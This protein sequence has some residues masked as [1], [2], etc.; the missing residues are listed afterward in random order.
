[1]SSKYTLLAAPPWTS[2]VSPSTDLNMIAVCSQRAG[3]GYTPSGSS[4]LD[5]SLLSM[6]YVH[7][8]SSGAKEAEEPPKTTILDPSLVVTALCIHRADGRVPVASTLVHALPSYS[9]RSLDGMYEY[10]TPPKMSILAPLSVATAVWPSRG[11]GESPLGVVSVH[12]PP[13]NL[14][15]HTSFSSSMLLPVPPNTTIL[16]SSSLPITIAL[17]SHRGGGYRSEG[18]SCDHVREPMS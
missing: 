17:C 6:V 3:G 1:M 11:S 18:A 4:T 2:I 14:Y 16:A 8:S 12:W 7:T 10:A 15:S 13:T 5:H 9:H